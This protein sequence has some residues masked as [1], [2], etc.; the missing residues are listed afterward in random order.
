MT[1]D[2][3]EKS[4][5]FTVHYGMKS[6]TIAFRTVEIF[7]P[8][9]GRAARIS[10]LQSTFGRTTPDTAVMQFKGHAVIQSFGRTVESSVTRQYSRISDV[11][12]KKSTADWQDIVV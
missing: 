9:C 1:R 3:F 2:M 10:K 5:E 6:W 4:C 11:S 12:S 8:A 7:K